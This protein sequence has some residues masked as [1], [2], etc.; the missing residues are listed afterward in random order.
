M[1]LEIS[2]RLLY[3]KIPRKYKSLELK[4]EGVDQSSL[5]LKPIPSTLAF[6]LRNILSEL[7]LFNQLKHSHKNLVEQPFVL[8]PICSIVDPIDLDP[9]PGIRFVK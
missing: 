1:I 6:S 3:S 4:S 7:T 8:W 5:N 2:S 9:D